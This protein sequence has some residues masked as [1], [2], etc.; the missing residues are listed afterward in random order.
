[1]KE[2][3]LRYMYDFDIDDLDLD[4]LKPGQGEWVEVCDNDAC[5][6]YFVYITLE[7]EVVVLSFFDYFLLK[8][9]LDAQ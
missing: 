1:M 5:R 2:S 3:S 6:N 4:H 8:N 9:N 7:D